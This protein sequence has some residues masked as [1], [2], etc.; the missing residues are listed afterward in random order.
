MANFNAFSELRSPVMVTDFET[1]APSCC[2]C[3]QKSLKHWASLCTV[4]QVGRRLPNSIFPH[5]VLE[6]DCHQKNRVKELSANYL[7]ATSL[8]IVRK[9]VFKWLK[10]EQLMVSTEA[11]P[12]AEELHS[13]RILCGINL[14]P[15]QKSPLSTSVY[16][17]NP[18]GDISGT[19]FLA[20]HNN[21]FN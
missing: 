4:L 1:L 8:L 19:S 2:P 6:W 9:R 5:S 13:H 10:I 3:V 14:K 18:L 20:L 15:P 16:S 11:E 21:S 12:E 17:H 7:M